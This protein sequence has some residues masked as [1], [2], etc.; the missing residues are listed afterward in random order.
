MSY[1]LATLWHERQRFLP[2]ILA[3]AFSALLIAL[4]CGLVLGALSVVSISVD[5][6]RADIWVGA[7]EVESVD[8]G[9]PIPERW[10]ARL[11]MAEVDRWEPFIQGFSYWHKPKGGSELCVVMG[12]RLY[13]GSLGAI[14]KLTPALRARL[15]EPGAVVVDEKDLARLDLPS[16]PAA[17]GQTAEVNGQRVRVVGIVQGLKGLGGAHVFCSI[18]TARTLLRLPAGQTT[19]LLARCRQ[20]GAAATVV[21]QLHDRNPDMAAFTTGDFSSS[22]RRH[23]LFNT[24]AGIMLGMAAALGLLVGAVITSQ[25]LYAATAASMRELA[26]LRALGIPRWRMNLTVIAQSF[27]VGLA[28]IIVSV[29]VIYG[30]AAVAQA[31]DAKVLLGQQLLAATAAGTMIMALLSGLAS[32][33]SLRLAEPAALLR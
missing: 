13:D 8:V 19:Y 20:P 18:D 2:A 23:W 32:L 30:L 31:L 11:D 12:A 33:R 29:P 21:K 6:T 4:Q 10:A 16:S 24:G 7:P 1:S 28:G 22:T 15:T 26:V 9:S 27:W 17:I 3:V 5:H 14:D 25:T